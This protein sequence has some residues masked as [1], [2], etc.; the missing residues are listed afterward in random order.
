[1]KFAS[2]TI[3]KKTQQMPLCIQEIVELIFLFAKIFL[4]RIHVKVI[5]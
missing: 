5:L 1:M 3:P 2:S 4:S